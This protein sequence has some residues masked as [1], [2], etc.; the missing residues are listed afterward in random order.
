MTHLDLRVDI[1]VPGWHHDGRIVRLAEVAT[2]E[3]V[4]EHRCAVMLLAFCYEKLRA[5][6]ADALR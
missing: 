2:P 4:E 6:L 3:R 1:G 5:E